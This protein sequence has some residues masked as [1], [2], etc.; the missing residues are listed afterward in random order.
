MDENTE[1]RRAQIWRDFCDAADA[2]AV[3]DYS[4]GFAHV[5]AYPSNAA[6]LRAF[7]RALRAG[8]LEKVGP[9]KYRKR[10]RNHNHSRDRAPGA[11]GGD[12]VGGAGDP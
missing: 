5:E 12:P 1:A 10:H 6:E 4:L 8:T 2:A 3:G 7:V 9:Y 11:E